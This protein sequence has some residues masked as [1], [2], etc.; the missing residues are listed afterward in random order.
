M[1]VN[2]QVILTGNIGSDLELKGTQENPRT[3]F[4]LAVSDRKGEEEITHWLWITVFGYSATNLVASAKKGTRV[5]VVG[6]L[7]VYSQEVE[8]QEY[9]QERVSVMANSVAIDMAFAQAEV[10]RTAKSGGSHDGP[11]P[12][13]D[14]K[15]AAKASTAKPKSG[16]GGGD[17]AF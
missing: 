14:E 6:K 17:F 1:A 10:T 11:P 5:T 15:P 7:Q 16:S 13:D 9:P 2:N 12:V 4:R 3:Q 8:G